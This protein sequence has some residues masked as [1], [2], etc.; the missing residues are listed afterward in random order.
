MACC[1][2]RTRV[3]IYNA[4]MKKLSEEPILEETSAKKPSSSSFF[5]PLLLVIIGFLLLLNNF[6]LLPWSIWNTLYKFWPIILILIGLEILLGR[7]RTTN[8]IVSLIGITITG[9]ILYITLPEIPLLIQQLTSQ[10][11]A[12]QPK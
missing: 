9:A 1:I 12:L 3:T 8:L 10:I 11:L 6:G 2:N 5:W 7:G 4:Q